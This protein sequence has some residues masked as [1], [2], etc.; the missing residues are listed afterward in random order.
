[1]RSGR[2][3]AHT[4]AVA[5][6]ATITSKHTH[7]RD[8]PRLARRPDAFL[9]MLI[10]F[11]FRPFEC[12]LPDVSPTIPCV[13]CVPAES[14]PERI[15]DYFVGIIEI[16]EDI[17]IRNEAATDLRILD[18]DGILLRHGIMAE[19]VALLEPLRGGI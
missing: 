6:I 13:L 4:P 2:Y 15:P 18:I 7:A 1:M 12:S 5:Q 16:S 19:I 17:A 14:L 11:T 3:T 8:T 10:P 9:L